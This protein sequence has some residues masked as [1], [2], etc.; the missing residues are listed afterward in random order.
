M[1]TMQNTFTRK[2]SHTRRT[3]S[4][5][6][7]DEI[8]NAI[9]KLQIRPGTKLSEVEIARQFDVS[10]Q[11]VREAFIRLSNM[12]LL[13]IRPQRATIVRKISL[14]EVANARFVRLSIE[15]EVA[16]QAILNFESAHEASFEHNLE[17]QR[18]MVISGDVAKFSDLDARFHELFCLV[19]G[20]P[21]AFSAI[22]EQMSKVDRL[23]VLSLADLNECKEVYEEHKLMFAD[24][25]AGNAEG[26]ADKI[27]DHLSRLDAIIESVAQ[28]NSDYFE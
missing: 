9:N 20:V 25:K 15:L 5:D 21:E 12:G 1:T 22:E 6:I 8:H 19:A 2:L 10:R 28:S 17:L 14:S 7:F 27:R 13:M 3:T 11:P 18:Q 24:L 16:R 26:L 23:C 4:D